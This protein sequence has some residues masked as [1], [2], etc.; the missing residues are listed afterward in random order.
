MVYNG[1]PCSSQKYTLK[2]VL[3]RAMVIA[4]LVL[5][6]RFFFFG[7]LW[8]LASEIGLRLR[9]PAQDALIISL[10]SFNAVQQ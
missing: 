5:Q 2:A 4:L 8:L 9:L 6:S 1:H 7:R 10:K 3:K